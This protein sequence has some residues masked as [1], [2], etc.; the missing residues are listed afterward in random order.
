MTLTAVRVMLLLLLRLVVWP[1]VADKAVMQCHLA[2]TKV[3]M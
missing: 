1:S 3:W 2:I